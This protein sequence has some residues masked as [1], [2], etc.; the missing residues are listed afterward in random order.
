M[1]QTGLHLDHVPASCMLAAGRNLPAG[2]G[3]MINVG[4]L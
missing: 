1:S 2:H 3:D 4:R